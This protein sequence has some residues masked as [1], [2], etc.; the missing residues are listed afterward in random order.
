MRELGI[1][2]FAHGVIGIEANLEGSI[3]S[4]SVLLTLGVPNV[5]AKAS[6]G[7]TRAYCLSPAFTTSSG[8][9]TTWENAS[10]I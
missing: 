7:R 2:E 9:S 6:L 5:W 10:S 3:L 8:Q 4:A 1:Q